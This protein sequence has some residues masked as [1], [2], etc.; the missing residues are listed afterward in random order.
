MTD[1]NGTAFRA[2]ADPTR[3]EILDLLRVSGPLRAGDI[4]AQFGE[5]T[6]I[7]VSKHLRVLHE[8]DL[9]EVVDSD[10][11]RERHYT[12]NAAGFDDLRVWLRRYDRFWQQRLSTLKR[13]AEERDQEDNAK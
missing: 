4:A 6:R 3:R 13:I 10:D 12:L 11:A 5:M 1:T 9:V 8:A 2:L 7:A